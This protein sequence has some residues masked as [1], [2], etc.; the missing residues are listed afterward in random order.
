MRMPPHIVSCCEPWPWL[1]PHHVYVAVYIDSVSINIECS[2]SYSIQYAAV[3]LCTVHSSRF[4]YESL[5]LSREWWE[6]WTSSSTRRL[7]KWIFILCNDLFPFIIGRFTFRIGLLHP[8]PKI[9]I[10]LPLFSGIDRFHP[11]ELS[12]QR[13]NTRLNFCTCTQRPDLSY[14]KHEV[15]YVGFKHIWVCFHRR[16]DPLCQ[17]WCF[18]CL[19]CCVRIY[20]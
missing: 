12:L 8:L 7:W 14:Q 11:N 6:G 5:T 4:R 17:L 16:Y 15:M 18:Q 10:Y 2:S 19:I 13:K 3:V 9:L 20:P 1:W